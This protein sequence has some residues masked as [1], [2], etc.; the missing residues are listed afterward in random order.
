MLIDAEKTL[1]EITAFR[2]HS[3][4]DEYLN[5]G[6]K[7]IIRKVNSIASEL[8]NTLEQVIASHNCLEVACAGLQETVS[9]LP[10]LNAKAF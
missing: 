2:K 7:K 1:E 4:S 6:N 10:R 5:G 9:E 8:V 3:A